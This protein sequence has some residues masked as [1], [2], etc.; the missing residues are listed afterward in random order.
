MTVF[1]SSIL[2]KKYTNPSSDVI[3]VLAGLDEVDSVATEFVAVLDGIIRN[4]NSCKN[5]FHP[6]LIRWAQ[7]CRI[8]VTLETHLTLLLVDIRHKAV[9]TAIAM[10][11]GAY[12]TSLIS[13]FTHRDLFP[14]IMKVGNHSACFWERY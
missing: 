10:T 9:R 13:Y 12:Q 3:T 1:L 8:S 14:S 5:F 11:S 2:R 7:F 6:L 4:S